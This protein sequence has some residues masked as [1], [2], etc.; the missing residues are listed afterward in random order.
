MAR[1]RSR[2][3]SSDGVPDGDGGTRRRRGGRL[4]GHRPR[5]ASAS[6]A[7]GAGLRAALESRGLLLTGGYVEVDVSA[8]D[9]PKAGLA[10]LA[11]FAISS[12]RWL[13]RRRA[14]V[15]AASDRRDH[16]LAAG[17]LRG[18]AGTS[19][20]SG[21]SAPSARSSGSA[22]PRLRGVPAQRGR[23]AARQPGQRHPGTGATPAPRSAWTPVTS[24]R[25]AATR[26]RS[27]AAGATG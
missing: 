16:R 21:S 7:L 5:P 2:S 14:R 24:S 15:P 18:D 11:R 12:T 3:A 19:G 27:C 1:S 26:S 20:G 17:P 6:S 8:D 13:R 23:H 22:R 4:R 25:P 10:E 9:A